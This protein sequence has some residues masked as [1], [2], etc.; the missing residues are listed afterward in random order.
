MA[1][2][3]LVPERFRGGCPFGVIVVG[4]DLMNSPAAM[5]AGKAYRA[6]TAS[7][8]IARRRTEEKRGKAS[9]PSRMTTTSAGMSALREPL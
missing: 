7:V 6:Q 5:L 8:D 9:F 2:A 4:V 3:V 1:Y